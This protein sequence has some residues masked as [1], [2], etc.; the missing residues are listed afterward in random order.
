M[1]KLYVNDEVKQ[2]F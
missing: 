1:I 2:S